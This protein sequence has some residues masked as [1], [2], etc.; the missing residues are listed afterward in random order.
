MIKFFLPHPLQIEETLGTT[1][2]G[3]GEALKDFKSGDK[4]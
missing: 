4:L 1:E 3:N 2:P